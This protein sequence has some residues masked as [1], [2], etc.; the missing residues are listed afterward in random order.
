MSN[1][2]CITGRVSLS[3]K[4]H[5]I[6]PTVLCVDHGHGGQDQDYSQPVQHGGGVASVHC[7]YYLYRLVRQLHHTLTLATRLH[8]H[9]THFSALLLNSKNLK[10]LKG[11]T[12]LTNK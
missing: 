7:S 6:L 1:L 5:I 4:L 12:W 11:A 10:E 3:I 2:P 8:K 9:T